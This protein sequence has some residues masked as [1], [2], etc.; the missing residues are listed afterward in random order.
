MNRVATTMAKY[1]SCRKDVASGVALET[2]WVTVTY[3]VI[4]AVAPLV[5]VTRQRHQTLNKRKESKAHTCSW[6]NN[7]CVPF[8]RTVC[9]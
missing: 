2:Y 9:G 8:R 4:V 6:L 5:D 7:A 1:T 3:A